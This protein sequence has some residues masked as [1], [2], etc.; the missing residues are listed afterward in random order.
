MKLIDVWWLLSCRDGTLLHRTKWY[1]IIYKVSLALP[2]S[3]LVTLWDPV[4]HIFVSDLSNIVPDNGLAPGRS[5]A[6]IWAN[7]GIL[8]IGPLGIHFMDIVIEIQTLSFNTIHLKMSTKW[9][10]FLIGLNVF[11][12][13]YSEQYDTM[14]VLYPR[15]VLLLICSNLTYRVWR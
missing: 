7:A 13:Q 5:Q 8:L 4:T 10:L 12:A 11:N 14:V 15:V 9:R 3:S 2:V 1:L 6:I